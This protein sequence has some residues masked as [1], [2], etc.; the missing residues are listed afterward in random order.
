MSGNIF[1]PLRKRC[2]IHKEIRLLLIAHHKL[3]FMFPAMG[4][5]QCTSQLLPYV[6]VYTVTFG[7]DQVYASSALGNQTTISDFLNSKMKDLDSVNHNEDCVKQV[8]RVLCHFHLP[9]C[10]NT[11]H[12][13][14]P[15]SICQEECQMVQGNC[16]DMWNS[17][18]LALNT[19]QRY[20]NTFV[21][22]STLLHWSRPRSV[23]QCHILHLM[24]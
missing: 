19:I 6:T 2:A 13:A 16:S 15:S 21:P 18:L 1:K 5:V 20:I 24:L 8:F 10:G 17:A 22:C 14:P 12:P 9:P 11:T 3:L 4:S 7:I 23:L